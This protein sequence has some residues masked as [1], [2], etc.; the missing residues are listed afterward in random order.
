MSL[1]DFIPMNSSNLQNSNFLRIISFL[2]MRICPLDSFSF[3]EIVL[4]EYFNKQL[5]AASRGKTIIFTSFLCLI[6][7]RG[8]MFEVN[9]VMKTQEISFSPD[10][11]HQ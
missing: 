7:L 2:L 1:Y 6:L 10:E 8:L 9:R 4:D 3:V 5:I 11:K